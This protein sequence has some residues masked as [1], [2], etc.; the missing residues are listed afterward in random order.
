MHLSV[1]DCRDI[2]MS[3][4]DIEF[5]D[6]LSKKIESKMSAGLISY[7][8]KHGIDVNYKTFFLLAYNEKH[9]VVGV[10]A[11]YTAFSEIYI[12]DLWVDEEY[13]YQGYGKRLLLALENKFRG[14]EFNN[15][16]LVTSQFQAPE[17]Y[18]KCGFQLEFI[19]ENKKNPQLSK[20]FFIKYYEEE[21][22]TQGLFL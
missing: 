11:A 5:V 13:R 9:D 8:K 15:I 17:F 3:D 7:E 19:R 10:L 22:Q 4:K 20:C 18:K 16:N 21:H 12:D 1:D 6:E 2:A 14:Q